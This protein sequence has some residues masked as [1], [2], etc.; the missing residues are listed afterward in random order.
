MRRHGSGPLGLA[1][2]FTPDFAY[3]AAVP[4]SLLASVVFYLTA[5]QAACPWC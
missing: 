5:G 4:V 1:R 3:A 2:A